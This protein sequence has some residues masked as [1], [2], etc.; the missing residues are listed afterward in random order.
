MKVL[1]EAKTIIRFMYNRLDQHVE[2]FIREEKHEVSCKKGCAHC[3]R[4]MALVSLAEG[5]RIADLVLRMPKQQ[6]LYVTQR[7]KESAPPPEM[8]VNDY[9][10]QGLYCGFLDLESKEC[11][12]YEERPA[13]CRYHYALSDP[14]LCTPGQSREVLLLDLLA[15]ENAIHEL[16]MQITGHFMTAPLPNM[17]LHCMVKLDPTKKKA[18]HNVADPLSWMRSTVRKE[19]IEHRENER[20]PF[21]SES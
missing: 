13:S 10:S 4:I 7:L 1:E 11:K 15:C 5:I 20:K 21:T 12:I 14:K 9:A 6:R 17:V 16:S 18:I 8:T 2:D 3:C 19:D